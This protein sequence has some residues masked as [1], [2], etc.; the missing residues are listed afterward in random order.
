MGV[1]RD[2]YGDLHNPPVVYTL[3]ALGFPTESTLE[4]K[5]PEIQTAL[6]SQYPIY[7]PI[8]SQSISVAQAK[9]GG[10]TISTDSQTDHYFFTDDRKSGVILKS[11]RVVCHTSFYKDFP[12]FSSELKFVLDVVVKV[13]ELSHYRNVGIRYIDSIS[14]PR[15]DCDLCDLLG[16]QM[17]PMPLDSDALECWHSSQS[18]F[19]KTSEGKLALRSFWMFEDA[20]CIP[21]DL[22]NSARL[23]YFD[24]LV[25]EKP[26]VVLDCDH[27]Y[28]PEGERVEK[29]DVPA[30]IDKVKVMHDASSSAFERAIN[31]P[32]WQEWN[33]QGVENV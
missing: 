27:H 15:G 16:P 12:S 29:L 21:P 6:K 2:K 32:L 25:R 13:L 3:F 30:L 17:S 24:N 11:D 19:Y 20:D 14:A 23:L 33:E 7:D 4:S 22:I 5:I 26:F 31:I 1:I 10:Q 8:V 9:D 18:N 28:S